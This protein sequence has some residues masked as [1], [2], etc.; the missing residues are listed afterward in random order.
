MI[1]LFIIHYSHFC[2]YSYKLARNIK[3]VS[4]FF[5]ASTVYVRFYLKYGKALKNSQVTTPAIVYKVPRHSISIQKAKSLHLL[6]SK[7]IL[8]ATKALFQPVS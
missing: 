2:K 4:I 7:A 8:P 1:I 3:F 5:K 6:L